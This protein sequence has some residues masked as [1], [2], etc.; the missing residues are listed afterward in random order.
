MSQRLERRL[1]AAGASEAAQL[2][3]LVAVVAERLGERHQELNDSM[4]EAIE[5]AIDD[6]DDS[7]L[8]G[9]LHASVEGN[10]ATILHM[11]RND[12]PLEKQQPVTAAS[13]YAVRLA[14]AGVSAAPLR[15]AYHIGSDDLLAWFFEEIERLDCAIDLK[16][17]LLH[18]MAG[19]L[20]T[21]VD[22]ITRV[23]MDVHEE[24]R[25]A[26]LLQNAS[27]VSQ[28]VQRVLDREPVDLEHF[29]RTTG[30]RLDHEHLAMVLW[31]EGGNQGVDLIDRLRSSAQVA[32]SAL[33]SASHLFTP[34][35]RST[36]RVWF[37]VQ[38]GGPDDVAALR[39]V[40]SRTPEIRAA[41]GAPSHRVVG[42]R[43]SLEQASAVRG[44]AAA[45]PSERNQVVSYGDD[46]MAVIALLARDLPAARRWVGEVLGA[47]AHDTEGAARLRETV[48]VYLAT[49]SMTDTSERLVLHR[50]TVK[51]R[52]AKA[53]AARGRPVVEGRLDLELALH[54]CH[55]L[56]AVVLRAP[57]QP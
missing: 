16:L 10:I 30:Y 22:W 5:Q 37:G 4:N 36:A 9:M 49:G 21:Y 42:F 52:L 38:G 18:H 25:Q 8:T 27:D 28:L 1:A 53:E 39:A 51:Y 57:E 45:A 55:V 40:L 46:G 13:E 24:E 54:A 29:A 56:G 19:W 26:L 14:R 33:R 23:V 17:R 47:L 12:I 20:H 6:L 44:I 2:R 48:R 7:E 41:L 50:N 35:D 32:A 34:V 15:R 11:L 3:D 31:V 43:R